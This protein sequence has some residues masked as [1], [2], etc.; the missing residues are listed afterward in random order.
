MRRATT[1][2][3]GV[4]LLYATAIP[5]PSAGSPTPTATPCIGQYVNIPIEDSCV[6]GET[7][8]GNHGDD[9]V[10]TV[11]LPFPYT[12]YDHTFNSINLSSN[13]NAQF[14]TTDN[15]GTNV[16]L[17]WLSHNFTIFSYWDDQRTDANPGCSAYP[18][19]TCGIYT[20][21]SGIAPNRILN[22]EWRAV[23][24][25]NTSQHANHELRLYE[26]GQPR[27]DVIYCTVDQGNTSATAGVQRDN[28]FVTQY[29]CNGSGG[30]ATGGQ[31][32]NYIPRP[33]PSATPS[34]TQTPRLTQTPRPRPTPLPRPGSAP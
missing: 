10:T 26:G 33:C 19:G 31:A 14:T 27:F 24:N 15:V 16:C 22:I 30:G 8:I 34:P 13:G 12:V 21:V 6:P 7:D 28:T 18:S 32:Y 17:P 25:N 20:S 5:V 23:Y 1:F 11:A 4:L 9:T 2:A 29:F 3:I